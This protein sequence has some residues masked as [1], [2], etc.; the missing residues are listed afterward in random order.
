MK[1]MRIPESYLMDVIP[2]NVESILDVGVGIGGIFNFHEWERR[3]NQGSLKRKVCTDIKILKDDIPA[4]WEKKICDGCSLPFNDNTF[5]VVNCTE[6]IQFVGRD[7][8]DLFVSELERVSKDLIYLTVSDE[9]GLGGLDDVERGKYVGF[10][11]QDYFKHK[12]YHTLFLDP[13]HLKVFKRK[14]G[15]WGEEF[16]DMEDYVKLVCMTI[17]GSIDSILD[18]GTG[19]KGVVAQDYYENILKIK[20]GYACDVWTLKDMDKNRWIG[21]KMNVLDLLDKGKGGIGEKSVDVMQ[22]F[23]FLEHLSSTD[24]YQFLHIAEK[25]ARKAVIISA[26]TY[27]HGDSVTEKAERDGNPYHEYRS[28]WHWKIFE[29]LG[30]K[31][32]YEHMR[33]GLTF[34]EE[35]IAWKVL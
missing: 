10:P 21:L 22:A 15:T 6:V 27:V 26:A 3:W 30:Y 14:V 24:G 11:G 32:N 9:S 33:Q 23:G 16:Y 8:W 13:H 5:D 28:V 7:K 17:E 4:T 34:S 20:K 29:K 19:Q 25:I 1:N 18:C 2:D 12:G 31:S 35:A